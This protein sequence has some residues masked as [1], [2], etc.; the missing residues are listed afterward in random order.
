MNRLKCEGK[1][2]FDQNKVEYRIE[3]NTDENLTLL[4]TVPVRTHIKNDTSKEIAFIILLVSQENHDGSG[5]DD[6]SP[7]YF[8][9]GRFQKIK[10]EVRKNED[11]ALIVVQDDDANFRYYSSR[12]F[13]DE[14][15]LYISTYVDLPNETGNYMDKGHFHDFIHEALKKCFPDKEFTT[16]PPQAVGN[17]GV[18]KPGDY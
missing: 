15:K 1:F 4:D 6:R 3:K 10:N 17:G 18:L 7:I 2:F 9:P 8:P 16:E 13:K 12:C 14:L 11:A 5:D